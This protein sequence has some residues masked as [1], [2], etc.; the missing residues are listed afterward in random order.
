MRRGD[1]TAAIPARAGH[2]PLIK[3]ITVATQIP[4]FNISYTTRQKI[5]WNTDQADL[6]GFHRFF[7]K[8]FQKISVFI[9]LIRQI[10]VP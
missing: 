2:R 1:R 3:H 9:D 7:Y 4:Y 8:I 6:R 5:K 10:R